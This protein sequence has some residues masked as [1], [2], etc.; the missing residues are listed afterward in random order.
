[1]SAFYCE[2]QN[3]ISPSVPGHL[4]VEGHHQHAGKEKRKMIPFRLCVSLQLI[5]THLERKY[6]NAS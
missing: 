6:A 3:Y 2:L 5:N 4:C 1:M